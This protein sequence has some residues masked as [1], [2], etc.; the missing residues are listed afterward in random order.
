M[1]PGFQFAGIV[2]VGE[3]GYSL[4]RKRHRSYFRSRRA[5]LMAGHFWYL[6]HAPE[7]ALSGHPIA[8]FAPMDSNGACLSKTHAR[9]AWK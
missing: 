9:Q 1:Y 3:H 6:I 2:L 4:F 7:L 8:C 5:V